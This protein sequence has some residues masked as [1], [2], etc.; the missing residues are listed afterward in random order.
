[1]SLQVEGLTIKDK[2]YLSS[3]KL[4]RVM[5]TSRHQETL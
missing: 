3:V 4:K 2:S 5:I 1:M